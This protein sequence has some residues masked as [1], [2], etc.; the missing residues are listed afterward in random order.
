MELSL[1]D[2]QPITNLSNAILIL[3]RFIAEE[4]LY[5][6]DFTKTTDLVSQKRTIPDASPSQK[7]HI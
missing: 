1:A 6:A 2:N 4:V 3:K 7:V 5:F